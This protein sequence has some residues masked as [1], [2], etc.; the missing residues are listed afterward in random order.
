LTE[1]K[2]LSGAQLHVYYDYRMYVPGKPGWVTDT[3]YDLLEYNYIKENNFD[4]LV[5]LEQRIRDYLNPE[6]V[7]IDPALF[8]RNQQFYRDADNA[9]VKGYHLIYRNTFGLIYVR[10]DLYQK[11]FSQ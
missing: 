9:G 11:F 4:V 2:P 1:L 8:A 7:G 10:D 6:V 5:L 3:T